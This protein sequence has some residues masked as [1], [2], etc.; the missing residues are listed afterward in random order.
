MK[1][2]DR[3]RGYAKQVGVNPAGFTKNSTAKNRIVSKLT[4]KQRKRLRL[5]ENALQ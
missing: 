3:I 1:A 5:K 2:N 4:S